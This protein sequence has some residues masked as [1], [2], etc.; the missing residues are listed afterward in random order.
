MSLRLT[1]EGADFTGGTVKGVASFG[2]FAEETVGE[3]PG[4]AFLT[5][6]RSVGAFSHPNKKAASNAILAS[7]IYKFEDV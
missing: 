2:F 5:T 7:F 3:G 4:F 6:C 1:V